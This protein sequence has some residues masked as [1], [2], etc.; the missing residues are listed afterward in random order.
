MTTL[1]TL[2]L[3]E[4]VNMGETTDV[5]RKGI[6]RVNKNNHI[7]NNENIIGSTVKIL[8]RQTCEFYNSI[9]RR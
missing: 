2:A 7:H 1:M 5:T 4:K 8:P 6:G 3:S 9:E